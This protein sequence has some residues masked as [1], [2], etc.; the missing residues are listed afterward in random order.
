MRDAEEMARLAEQLGRGFESRV[1]ITL[2]A[3][4]EPDREDLRRELRRLTHSHVSAITKRA[5]TLAEI[6]AQE[7][8]GRVR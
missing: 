1:F 6:L 8:E 3:W 5:K 7:F 4:Q 2:A